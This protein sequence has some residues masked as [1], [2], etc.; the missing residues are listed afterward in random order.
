MLDKIPDKHRWAGK[1]LLLKG[2]DLQV[3]RGS[4]GEVVPKR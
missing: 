2:Q 4:F 3:R 1:L